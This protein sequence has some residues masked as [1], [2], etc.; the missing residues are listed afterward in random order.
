MITIGRYQVKNNL[1]ENYQKNGQA[2]K[3]LKNH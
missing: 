2:R 1:M 3:V